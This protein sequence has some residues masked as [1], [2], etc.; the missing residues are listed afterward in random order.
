M[1]A[2]TIPP[3]L[4]RPTTRL[5][6]VSIFLGLTA[7]APAKKG[8]GGGG[9]PTDPPPALGVPVAVTAPVDYVKTELRWPGSA[10][11]NGDESLFDDRQPGYLATVVEGIN[12]QGRA[13]GYVKTAS[14]FRYGVVSALNSQGGT[15][16][17]LLDL[18]D[19]FSSPAGWRIAYAFDINDAGLIV[20]QLIP[21]TDPY[22]M[23][24]S[25]ALLAIADLA[26]TTLTLVEPANDSPEQYVLEMNENGDLLVRGSV[27]AGTAG[28]TEFEHYVYERQA[29]GSYLRHN[30]PGLGTPG[31]TDWN[32]SFN[33]SLQ[34]ASSDAP[35]RS[36]LFRW[37]L[38]ASGTYTPNLLWEG[39]TKGRDP[40]DFFVRGITNQQTDGGPPAVY[41]SLYGGKAE[42]SGVYRVTETERQLIAPYPYVGSPG[43]LRNMSRAEYGREEILLL[44]TESGDYLY[45]IYQPEFGLRFR[46]P[47]DIVVQPFQ[48]HEAMISSPNGPIGPDNYHGGYIAYHV[49]APEGTA[50]QSF[51]LTPVAP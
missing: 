40:D 50:V 5:V 46:L 38:D 48:I 31:V 18:N 25:Q 42:P 16:D 43:P 4:L 8:G 11:A 7:L 51:V 9:A 22:R 39:Y 34:V 17:L 6:S 21:A 14:T 12:G 35:E 27:L 44:D 1:K 49:Y 28:L 15:S 13:V 33:N 37:D 36:N 32:P 19:I 24:G 2:T 41:A 26:S 23:T 3:R 45:Q 10:D 29:D 30:L 47:A 20:C